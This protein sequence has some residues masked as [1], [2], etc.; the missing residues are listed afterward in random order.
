[1]PA[2]SCVSIEEASAAKMA[3]AAREVGAA[4]LVVPVDATSAGELLGVLARVSCRSC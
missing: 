3:E 1:V 4:L 2:L